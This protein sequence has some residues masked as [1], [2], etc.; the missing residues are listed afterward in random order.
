VH[1]SI[2]IN[3]K[4]GHLKNPLE[5][6]TYKDTNDYLKRMEGYSTLAAKELY[7]EGRRACIFDIIFRPAATSSGCSF[8]S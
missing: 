1:E 3:G 8:F 5:H 6:F 2:K 7:K 4:T